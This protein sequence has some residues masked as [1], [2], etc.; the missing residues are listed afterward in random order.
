MHLEQMHKMKMK[1]LDFPTSK[2]QIYP[3]ESL[4]ILGS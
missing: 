1:S 3:I 4:C 2:I